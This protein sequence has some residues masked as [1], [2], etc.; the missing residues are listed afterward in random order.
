MLLRV[1]CYSLSFVASL[2]SCLHLRLSLSLSLASN[3]QGRSTT[4]APALPAKTKVVSKLC[5]VGLVGVYLHVHSGNRR[6]VQWDSRLSNDSDHQKLAIGLSL[7][8]V[9]DLV[10][11]IPNLVEM[12]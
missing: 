9:L 10:P 8:H 1:H 11:T 3:G 7:R 2:L 12:G 5:Y 6:N 4:A